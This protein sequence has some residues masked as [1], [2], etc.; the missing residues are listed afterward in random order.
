MPE[1][2]RGHW[3]SGTAG[4][5]HPFSPESYPAGGIYKPVHA[6]SI[7]EVTRFALQSFKMSDQELAAFFALELAKMVI[8]ECL[9]QKPA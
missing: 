6:G 5:V 4:L 8:D 9:I 7:E 1:Q 3:I 2:Y